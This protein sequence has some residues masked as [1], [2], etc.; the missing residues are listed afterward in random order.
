MSM[1]KI[2]RHPA[3]SKGRDF[4][5]GDLHGHRSD[6][7]TELRS[8]GFAANAGDRLFLVGDLVDR[9]PDS[10]GCL[11]FLEEAGVYAVRGN[12]EQAAIDYIDRV[13]HPV[14]ELDS[15]NFEHWML[16]C[17]GR[18]LVEYVSYASRESLLALQERLLQLPH[19]MVVGEGAQR[20]NIV[21]AELADPQAPAGVWLDADID[22]GLPQADLNRLIWGRRLITGARA[23]LV[24]SVVPGLSPTYCGHTV[25]PA[26]IQHDSHVFLD[27][28]A[29]TEDGW[30]TVVQHPFTPQDSLSRRMQAQRAKLN[31]PIAAG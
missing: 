22:A 12:H 1:I 26:P 11:K 5:V 3:N 27:T 4:L 16:Q 29:F 30:L 10:M 15:I 9:G 18:W 6:L 19:V 7:E 2:E 25:L 8:Q 24:D 20:F 13:L 21:H 14:S 17:G 28:G 23:T 31:F